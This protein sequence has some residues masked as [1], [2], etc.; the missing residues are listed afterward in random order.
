MPILRP[1]IILWN[2]KI[3]KV[4]SL[5]LWHLP[6]HHLLQGHPDFRDGKMW[7]RKKKVHLQTPF[8]KWGNQ[9]LEIVSTGPIADTRL[10]EGFRGQ[11]GF[12]SSKICSLGILAGRPGWCLLGISFSFLFIIFLVV[13][14]L[15]CSGRAFSSC[16]EQGLLSTCRA[17]SSPCRDFSCCR[18]GL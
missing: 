15:S 4:R 7:E 16:G 3:A 18:V 17:W 6:K 12:P 11:L 8:Y 5:K 13:L 9:N 2:T 10:G 14:G 1:N